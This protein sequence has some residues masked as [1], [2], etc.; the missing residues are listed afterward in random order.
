MGTLQA[1]IDEGNYDSSN[2]NDN[3]S[4][5]ELGL[6]E[7]ANL[8][9]GTSMRSK[10]FDNDFNNELNQSTSDDDSVLFGEN[11]VLNMSSSLK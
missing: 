4:I 11:I 9:L 7:L 10:G 8:P 5:N 6:S 2:N 3:D 1:Y